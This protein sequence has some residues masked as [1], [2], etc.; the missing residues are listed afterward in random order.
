MI[1]KR[2]S[3]SEVD[4]YIHKLRLKGFVDIAS[5]KTSIATK[6][7]LK[8]G[9]ECVTITYTTNGWVTIS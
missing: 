7:V 2:V 3:K 1:K 4:F 9:S 6:V 8:R 5:E